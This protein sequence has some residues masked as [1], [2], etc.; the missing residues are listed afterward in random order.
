M[1]VTFF[2]VIGIW[3]HTQL[4][5]ILPGLEAF[6]EVKMSAWSNSGIFAVLIT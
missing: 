3:S 4:H 5:T 2:Q 1:S 6:P